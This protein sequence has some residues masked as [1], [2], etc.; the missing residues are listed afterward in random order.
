M[1]FSSQPTLVEVLDVALEGVHLSNKRN[2]NWL[3]RQ[4][5]QSLTD[6][7]PLL[8]NHLPD[9]TIKKDY[10]VIQWRNIG[11]VAHI[12]AINE[13]RHLIEHILQDD[14]LPVEFQL[15]QEIIT[16]RSFVVEMAT[17]PQ[18][19]QLCNWAALNDDNI[20]VWQ[21]NQGF[22]E[23]IQLLEA[24]LVGH[25]I[26]FCKK[27]GF[28]IPNRS[29]T[30]KILEEGYQNN[31]KTYYPQQH[32]ELSLQTFDLCYE[33]NIYLPPGLGLGKAKRK[34][35]G[36]QYPIEKI[37]TLTRTKRKITSHRSS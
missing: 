20:K 14:R 8:H 30:V 35:F 4:I 22:V 24:C 2:T 36:W 27:I 12:W 19:Y 16:Q 31:G 29:L 34:G 32:N 5:Q 23:R 37:D 17:K 10:S 33:A 25:I 7:A 21:R 13:G 6:I 1:A 26:E 11:G 15:S 28:T 3:T 9:G 18:C